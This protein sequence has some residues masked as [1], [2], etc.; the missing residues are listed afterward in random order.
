MIICER[1]GNMMPNSALLCLACGTLSVFTK[2]DLNTPTQYE[3]G[4]VPSPLP[5]NGQAEYRQHLY[6][7]Q[8]GYAPLP[9]DGQL[10]HSLSMIYAPISM[11]L[12]T[13]PVTPLAP[14]I[15]RGA[16]LLEVLL[17]ICPGIFGIGWLMAGE[18]I[19]GLLLLACSII[20]YWPILLIGFFL[21]RIFS[22]GPGLYGLIPLAI[23]TIILN[24]FLL[25]RDIKRKMG[26]LPA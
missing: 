21:S 24:I 12:M 20:L 13:T 7:P 10:S 6:N 2:P 19:T 17:N 18:T 5:D 9:S 14:S 1:C 4:F 16:I 26:Y 15:K 8:P 22:V 23:G 11:N 3:L 25:K